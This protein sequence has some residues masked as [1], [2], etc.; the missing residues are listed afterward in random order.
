MI[1]GADWGRV[2]KPSCKS[3]GGGLE[4]AEF[5]G[6]LNMGDESVSI[7]EKYCDWSESPT[8]KL[9]LKKIEDY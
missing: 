7:K 8:V 4:M 9:S 2:L 6:S 1:V 3:N 5:L